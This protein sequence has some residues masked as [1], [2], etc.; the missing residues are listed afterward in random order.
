M[1]AD[2][3]KCNFESE[4]GHYGAHYGFRRPLQIRI[5]C[6]QEEH[7]VAVVDP[8]FGVH[9]HGAVG[10]AV[11]GD[12]DAGFPIA[13]LLLERSEMRFVRANRGRSPLL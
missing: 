1:E 4:I 5:A 2:A 13:N 11:K 12:A 6:Q 9:K 10:I 7:V 3:F 8:A